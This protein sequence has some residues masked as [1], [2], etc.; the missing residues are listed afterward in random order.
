[1]SGG[2]EDPAPTLSD[3]WLIALGAGTAL[4]G[5]L[6]GSKAANLDRMLAAGLPVPR[7]FCVTTR[8]Y[9]EWFVTCPHA[10]SALDRLEDLDCADVEASR[11]LAADLRR[12][13]AEH[14]VPTAVVAAVVDTCDRYG[15]DLAWAVR[16]SATAE[17]GHETSF[18][19]QHDTFLNIHGP[20]AVVDTVRRCWISLFTDRA[21]AYRARH[22]LTQRSL[23]M[24][25][26]L[27]EMVPADW[28]G[29]AFTV[30]PVT[31]DP[32]HLVI[33]GAPGLGD[34]LVSGKVNPERFVIPHDALAPSEA[35]R[36]G[37][38]G[39]SGSA[40]PAVADKSDARPTLNDLLARRVV[41]LAIQA[42]QL[43]G[44]PQDV[45]WA[46]ADH[47]LFLLQSRPITGP[48]VW[49][50]PTPDVWSNAN[51]CENFPDVLTPMGWSVFEALIIGVFRPFL[52]RF[53][54]DLDARPWFGPIAGRMYMN[55][56]TTDQV[57]RGM[58]KFARLDPSEMLGGAHVPFD[59]APATVSPIRRGRYLVRQLPWLVRFAAQFFSRRASRRGTAYL[60]TL[61]ARV[62]ALAN[63]DFE[64]L[65]DTAL[66]EFIPAIRRQAYPE[67]DRMTAA[68]AS[69]AVC[70]M[71]GFGAS[72]AVLRL[73]R[74]WL[75][76]PDGALAK[77]LLTG[78]GNMASA[79]SA[80]DLWRLAAWAREHPDIA[81][82]LE[83][84]RPFVEISAGLETTPPG[85]EFLERWALW[86]NRHGHH[87]RGE[88]D[89]YRPRWSEEPDLV[90]EL[91]RSY[92][93]AAGPN[94][95]LRQHAD[96][97]RQRELLLASCRTRLRNPV[98]RWLFTTL[99]DRARHGLALRENVKSV[100]VSIV[101]IIRRALFE[102]GHRLA[103]RGVLR[104]SDDVFFLTLPELREALTDD[105]RVHATPLV[106]ARRAEFARNRCL[107]PPPIIDGRSNAPAVRRS[108]RQEAPSRY[109]SS[110]RQEALRRH[111]SSRRQEAPIS[112]ALASSR[113]D[114]PSRAGAPV[115]NPSTRLVG[116][117]VSPGLAVGKA[118]VILH[119]DEHEPI[120]PG[121]IL[122]APATDPGW[123][124]Y[125]LSSAAIVV[126]I[127]GQLS[128]GSILAREFGIPA[129]VNV[130]QAT[131][132]IR[133]G[134]VIRVDGDQGIVTLE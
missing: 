123:T 96:Q 115:P 63:T 97:S 133:T 77:R 76:D 132:L 58:Q 109:R 47:R 5:S 2:P 73:A 90:L 34:V 44:A 75:D 29:V 103:R 71:L 30:D 28:A 69:A 112:P 19:G 25:V 62:E 80:V 24:A 35:E 111:R 27:Q 45:E 42:E 18:A 60:D 85:R 26:I 101:Q 86:M 127:G 56:T 37:V 1:M 65:S 48:A 119:A 53:G 3:P 61:R 22:H 79:Q 39:P 128:H 7:A 70:M 68:V 82:T 11:S 98:K 120:E 106:A 8:A 104:R 13:L 102:A 113:S 93:R 74:R 55:L 126:D 78:T 95:I 124:P 21:V 130:G 89:I 131:R 110:R 72:I 20:D 4:T 105:G 59:P 81:R 134:Q 52:G 114:L 117:A 49:H 91:L 41:Q 84:A 116:L 50:P 15:Q 122:V 10:R 33:E 31:G 54:I 87:A 66:G 64:A 12:I 125:F 6:A 14:P 38:R 40:C 43:F 100:A 51:M 118:R 46:V 36:V 23:A 129:V 94:D 88:M 9:H 92:L 107:H 121:E 83:A 99:I 16:S 32:A 17:D 57:F 108:R 67:A